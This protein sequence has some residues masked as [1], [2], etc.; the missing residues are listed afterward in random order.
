[1][2]NFKLL[3]PDDSRIYFS[4]S[5]LKTFRTC[6][7]CWAAQYINKISR[8]T[9]FWAQRGTDIHSMLESYLLT[10]EINSYSKHLDLVKMGLKYLPKPGIAEV[11]KYFIYGIDDINFKGYIDFLYKSA[12]GLWV[13]GD[14]KTTSNISKNALDKTSLIDDIQANIYAAYVMGRENVDALEFNWIYYETSKSPFCEKIAVKTDLTRVEK[15][16]TSYLDDCK[17]MLEYRAINKR[18]EEFEPTPKCKT[19]MGCYKKEVF[20]GAKPVKQTRKIEEVL[21]ESEKPVSVGGNSNGPVLLINCLFQKGTPNNVHI[22]SDLILKPVMEFIEKEYGVP[23]YSFIEYGKGRGAFYD[24]VKQKLAELK[25][26]SSDFLC[27]SLSPESMDCLDLLI[28][29][30]SQVIRGTK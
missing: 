20:E 8:P 7:L 26:T 5:Q 25:L 2:K 3:E 13:I 21:T 15:N 9:S 29:Y 30:S 22:A 16:I 4:A 18:A 12:S 27:V 1:M 24:A 6:K 14:H 19:F 11:E 17:E 28:D 23:H 10:G